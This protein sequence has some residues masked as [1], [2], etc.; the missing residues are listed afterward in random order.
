MR[1]LFC[2]ITSVSAFRVDQNPL[3]RKVGAATAATGGKGT[4]TDT[5]ESK[6]ILGAS[7]NKAIFITTQT[8]TAING[9][10]ISSS[11]TRFRDDSLLKTLKTD[12]IKKYGQD[13]W[14]A[15]CKK[16]GGEAELFRLIRGFSANI[17]TKKAEYIS[18]HNNSPSVTGTRDQNE[19]NVFSIAELKYDQRTATAPQYCLPLRGDEIDLE[20]LTPPTQTTDIGSPVK[21]EKPERT[22]TGPSVGQVLSKPGYRFDYATFNSDYTTASYN[23]HYESPDGKEHGS[24]EARVTFAVDATGKL[25]VSVQGFKDGVV[26]SFSEDKDILAV[27]GKLKKDGTIIST[28]AYTSADN[29]VSFYTK[30][31]NYRPGRFENRSGKTIPVMIALAKLMGIEP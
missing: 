27:I 17:A 10:A 20:I 9:K 8:G 6:T 18:W 22:A 2:D 21:P 4:V 28:G 7:D 3:D 24:V 25:S 15:A 16:A 11:I 19:D 23:L 31:D 13:K 30:V 1:R 26:A 5:F 12:Y 14:D 29:G